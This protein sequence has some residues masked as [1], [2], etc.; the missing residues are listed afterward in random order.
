MLDRIR[1]QSVAGSEMWVR[2]GVLAMNLKTAL[3]KMG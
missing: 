3:V 2:C 1:Y